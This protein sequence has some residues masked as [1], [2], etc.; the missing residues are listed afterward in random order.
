M[1]DAGMPML[2]VIGL[3][4]FLRAMLFGS[5]SIAL[6]NLALRHQ[7]GVLQRSVRRPRLARWD[8]ILWVGLSRLWTGWRSSLVIVRPATVLAWHRQ[9]FQLYWRWRSKGSAVGRPKLDAE[10][11]RLIRRMARE[12]PTWG[13]RRIQAE[14]ALLGYHVA[15]LTVAK[16]MHRTSP[17]PSPTWHA[18]LTA[19]ARE[20]VAIDF[21]VVAT[22]TFRLLFVFVVL[23]HDRRELLH[24][25]V[26]DHPTA[27]WTARQLVEAFPD[28]TAPKYLLRD[29]D[30]IYG[31]EFVRRVKGV[32]IRE[33]LTAPRAPWQN[34]FVERVIGS[35]RRECLDH[36]VVLSERHL[37]RLLRAY[38]AY[39]NTVRPHQAL[40][41]NSPRPREV[42]S[43]ALGHVVAIPQVGGLHHLY[44]RAA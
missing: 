7:L 22:L 44:Q 18:F 31:E 29:R 15:E 17:R 5:A 34:P 8:R 13:R 6:E 37:R 12:N 4:T 26:T 28:D 9:G 41:Q 33:V 21:F 16:Y 35:I 3:G 42:Q 11:R 30:A 2:F 32:G 24:V 23:R 20:I 39:Y 40:E 19:H 36:M 27:G 1:P 43:P 38:L 14:L 25:N 10:I